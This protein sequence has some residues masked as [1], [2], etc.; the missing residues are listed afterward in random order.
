[1]HNTYKIHHNTYK[2][3]TKYIIIHHNT[4]TTKN[5]N[6]TNKARNPFVNKWSYFKDVVPKNP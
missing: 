2:T 4:S 6:S 3:Y 5:S 1:M